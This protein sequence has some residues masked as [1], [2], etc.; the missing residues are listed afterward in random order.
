MVQREID[1]LIVIQHYEFQVQLH[2][3]EIF[4]FF[5]HSGPIEREGQKLAHRPKLGQFRAWEPMFE[6]GEFPEYLPDFWLVW[7]FGAGVG[8]STQLL[9]H[10]C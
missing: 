4:Q 7:L 1:Y 6:E 9:R 2:H 3:G 5:F 8:S 10:G